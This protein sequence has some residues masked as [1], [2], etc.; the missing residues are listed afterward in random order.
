MGHNNKAAR[1]ANNKRVYDPE[2]SGR[3]YP[4]SLRAARLKSRQEE[5]NRSVVGFATFKVAIITYGVIY[6]FSSNY[7]ENHVRNISIEPENPDKVE[8]YMDTVCVLRGASDLL[9]ILTQST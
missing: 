8:A 7:G 2:E 5:C 4:V 9:N 1:T 6:G 3:T